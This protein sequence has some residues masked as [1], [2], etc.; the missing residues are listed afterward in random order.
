MTDEVH[1]LDGQLLG[2]VTQE[3][4]IGHE[5]IFVLG[6]G[7]GYRRGLSTLSLGDPSFPDYAESEKGE[8]QNKS[9]EMAH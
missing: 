9:E 3:F 4:Q 1:I 8:K 5:R 6:V 2:R 7:Q